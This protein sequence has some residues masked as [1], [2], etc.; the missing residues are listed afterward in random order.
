VC[1]SVIISQDSILK[2]AAMVEKFEELLREVNLLIGKGAPKAEVI[3][4]AKE[5]KI[6]LI[7]RAMEISRATA[8]LDN[9]MMWYAPDEPWQWGWVQAPPTQTGA[10]ASSSR[11][12]TRKV[13]DIAEVLASEG[14]G[15]VKTEDI[16]AR[17]QLAGEQGTVKHLRTAIGNILTSTGRWRR[18]ERGVYEQT[19]GGA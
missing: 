19:G 9:E 6:E 7:A 13:L 5:A 1:L 18:L 17:L 12:R 16:A 3:A 14:A 11:T 2:E 4:K 15:R 8:H 10:T